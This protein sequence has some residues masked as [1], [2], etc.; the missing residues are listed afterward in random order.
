MLLFL[1]AALFTTDTPITKSSVPV[2]VFDTLGKQIPLNFTDSTYID[3]IMKW[4]QDG[5][6]SKD[7]THTEFIQIKYHGDSTKFLP[8][9]AVGIQVYNDSARTVKHDVGLND[10]PKDNHWIFKA[11]YAD[12]SLIRDSL[13]FNFSNSV[14]FYASRTAEVESF[15]VMDGKNVS[16]N[17]YQ[18]VLVLQ[19]KVQI[20]KHRV[21]AKKHGFILKSDKFTPGDGTVTFNSS[22]KPCYGPPSCNNQKGADGGGAS[23][24]LD[25][26]VVIQEPKDLKPTDP[27]VR[28][29]QFATLVTCAPCTNDSR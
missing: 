29:C 3:G 12:R 18:G 4:W 7:P 9:K 17:H 23:C 13:L 27:E 16:M 25:F 24:R 19:E 15:L 10:F 26:T 14:G 11:P 6:M 2:V 20:S 1:A 5:D 21:K 8:K 28:S 22:A